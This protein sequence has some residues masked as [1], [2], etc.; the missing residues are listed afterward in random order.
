[1]SRI[2]DLLRNVDDARR[3]HSV[4][5]SRAVP[6]A[7]AVVTV[8]NN[9]GGIGKS[10]LAMN[11]AVY[12]R[13]LHEDLPILILSLDDQSPID[14]LFAL[15]ETPPRDSLA[16][17]LRRGTLAQAIREGQYGI[18]YV[19]TCRTIA[20]LKREVRDP[21]VV[22][23]AIQNA[24]RQGVVV[25]DTKSDLEILT[26]SAIHAGRL[27][28]VPVAD[29]ASLL[30]A[31]RV[32]EWLDANRIPRS[33]ARVVL[34]LIDLRVK[35]REGESQDILSLL[36]TEIRKR[37]LP[38]LESFVSRSPKIEGLYSNPE[39]RA[40][41]VLHGAPTSTVHHQF[42]LLASEVSGILGVGG[43]I[44][45]PDGPARRRAEFEAASNDVLPV[46]PSERLKA[47]SG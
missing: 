44:D 46:N 15:D 29:H 9:K 36:L 31:V 16:H 14:R 40:H 25:V 24:R 17:A 18:D 32:F 11:L 37:E 23:R 33:S 35:Y 7:A 26:Q 13:A 30:E 28:L 38:V 47:A 34:S 43:S 3:S 6:H 41:S 4:E 10:T 2:Y 20:E 39:G 1:M 42:Q 5:T 27:L 8:A 12:L 45:R 19:P 22:A 21:G